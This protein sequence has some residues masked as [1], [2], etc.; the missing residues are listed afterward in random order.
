MHGRTRERENYIQTRAFMKF[1]FRLF[2]KKF[3]LVSCPF[4]VVLL[5]SP[6][7]P[8]SIVMMAHKWILPTE[9][10]L[11][12]LFVKWW[13]QDGRRQKEKKNRKKT[14][15]SFFLLQ[16][17]LSARPPNHTRK[18][19][20][21]RFNI[22]SLRLFLT[23]LAFLVRFSFSPRTGRGLYKSHPI[24]FVGSALLLWKSHHDGGEDCC[25]SILETSNR[26]FLPLSVRFSLLYFDILFTPFFLIIILWWWC[27][28]ISPRY[29]FS[30]RKI[31]VSRGLTM[32]SNV[33]AH[34]ISFSLCI[35]LTVS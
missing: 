14:R 34:S 13:E 10:L 21:F 12:F 9:C 33:C 7:P 4:F 26:F 1:S 11:N 6:P 3:L 19:S 35:G 2:F 23:L 18:T 22:D 25:R 29:F 5:V 32:S 28:Y 24:G 30:N 16:L 31:C 17:S 15:R 27:R 20:L 8:H